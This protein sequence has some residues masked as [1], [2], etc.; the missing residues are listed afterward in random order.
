IVYSHRPA[1]L[2]CTSRFSFKPHWEPPWARW[3]CSL[4]LPY[5]WE[6][7][8]DTQGR[9]YYLDHINEKSSYRDPRSP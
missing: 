4:G 2:L 3:R 9:L 7:A 6:Q 5:A 1:M 8:I